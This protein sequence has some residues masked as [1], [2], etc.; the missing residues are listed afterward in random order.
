MKAETDGY[1]ASN[2]PYPHVISSVGLRRNHRWPVMIARLP[3]EVE[4]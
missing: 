3:D 4:I 1:R 2:R